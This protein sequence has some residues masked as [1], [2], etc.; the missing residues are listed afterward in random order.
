MISVALSHDG[1][2]W[3]YKIVTIEGEVAGSQEGLAPVDP[4]IVLL[5]DGRYRLFYMYDGIIYSAISNS[6]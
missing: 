5:E 2:S 6:G 3:I 1:V 4:D